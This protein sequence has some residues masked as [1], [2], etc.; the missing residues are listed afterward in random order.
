MVYLSASHIITPLGEGVA[1]NAEAVM[2]GQTRLTTHTSVH[3]ERLVETAVASLLDADRYRIDGYSLFESLCI[4][5]IMPFAAKH[6]KAMA[7]AK[8]VFVLSSTKGNLWTP[9]S[10]TAAR[11]AA[12]FGNAVRPIVVSTACTSGVSAQL[13]AW[14]LLMR[15]R[16]DWAVVVGADVQRPF[17]VSGFQSFKAL[18]NAPCRPFDA[19]RDGLNVGEA[20]GAILLSRNCP[21]QG[22]VWQLMGGCI[23]NDANH[24]SGPSRTAEGSWRCLE[25]MKRLTGDAPAMVSVHGTG[26]AYNDEMESIALYRAGLTD[27]PVSAL[28]GYYG[29]TMGAAGLVETILCLYALEK[30]V[31]L[32]TKGYAQQGTTYPVAVSH[33]PRE[34]KGQ[35]LIK[36][37]SGFGGV[38]AA[39]GWKKCSSDRD[40]EA[41]SDES[42]NVETVA[43]VSIDATEDLLQLYR[44]TVGNYPKFFKMDTLS[45]L[46]F[47]GVERL[48]QALRATMPDFALDHEH[49]ALVFANR[50]ASL[51]ADT[52]YQLTIADPEQYYPSPALFVY[53]LPN[54]VAGELAIRHQLYG[55]TACYVLDNPSELN[56]LAEDTLAQSSCTQ[57]V[58]GWLECTDA[59]H[60]SAHIELRIKKQ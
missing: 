52:A 36:L 41:K 3:G 25:E 28:K 33:L 54:I 22:D 34:A 4:R 47:I 16:Y 7:S 26:T 17:I 59:T 39:V 12:F 29:H 55:E 53:T 49:C 48:L 43:S 46:G 15:G 13:T 44:E 40:V 56:A 31:V 21:K 37:L 32:P 42:V 24:I 23:H 50:S 45:R 35:S 10:D 6:G 11:V 2:R 8:C 38:N 18:S 51:Q 57:A 9:M 27:V 60:Y 30:G 58:V 5:C 20:V 19:E 1:A 14:R